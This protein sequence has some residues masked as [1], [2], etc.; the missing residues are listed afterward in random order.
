[1]H[2]IDAFRTVQILKA[3]GLYTIESKDMAQLSLGVG[4]GS[5][6][7]KSIHLQPELTILPDNSIEFHVN[8][9]HA[10]DVILVDGDAQRKEWVNELN[11]TQEHQITQIDTQKTN[12]KN[13]ITNT[14]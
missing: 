8:Q 13:K 11:K 10:K 5:K 4:S 6:D 7:L 9:L 3:L 12:I 2:S 14:R 1:M